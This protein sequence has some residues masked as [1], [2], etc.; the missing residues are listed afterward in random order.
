M[1]YAKLASGHQMPM[2]G[3]GTW[4][5]RGEECSTVVRAALEMGYRHVDTRG[6]RKQ[7][8]VGPPCASRACNAGRAVQHLQSAPTPALRASATL[9][10]S[11]LRDLDTTTSTCP[12]PL[13]QSVDPHG[14]DFRA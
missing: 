7:V 4:T 5:L 6:L 8:A 11:T 13:H 10:R 14:G 12:E 2:V 1:E 9:L 3:L